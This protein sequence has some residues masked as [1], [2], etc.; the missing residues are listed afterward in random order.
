VVFVVSDGFCR[1]VQSSA[2]LGGD[3]LDVT[4]HVYDTMRSEYVHHRCRHR[5]SVPVLLPST[6]FDSVPCWLKN[7]NFYLWPKHYQ[8]LFNVF[9]N[10]HENLKCTEC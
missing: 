2:T 7:T 8:E 10:C 9:Y 4:R 5:R 3:R 1:D 6:D